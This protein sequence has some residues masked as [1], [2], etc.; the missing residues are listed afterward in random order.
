M[1]VPHLNRRLVLEAPVRVADG[2]GGYTQSWQAL[3]THYA[4][5]TA[6][7][8]REKAGVAVPLS[9]VAYRIVVRAGLVGASSRPLPEQRF[10]DGS[11]VFNILA[12]AEADAS[13]RYLTC[14][15]EEENVT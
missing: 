6:R 15:A 12:V 8:G 2:A 7:T 14:T 10:R 4:E 3:G 1:K 9:R 13:G 5:V 11:R